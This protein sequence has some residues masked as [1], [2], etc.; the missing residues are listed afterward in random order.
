M[1]NRTLLALDLK[2]DIRVIASGKILSGFH[3]LRTLAMGADMVSSARGM[4]LALGCIRA[5][6]CNNNHCPTGVATEDPSLYKGLIVSDK[7]VRVANYHRETVTA[8]AEL[9]TAAGLE[10]ASDLRRC[11]V[12]R[13]IDME[14]VRTLE[15]IHPY[16]ETGSLLE[17]APPAWLAGDYAAARAEAWQPA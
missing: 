7:R 5:L 1:R 2:R 16:P 13:R 4:M 12:S 11:H 10:T 6:E 14:T 15:E 3:A 9:L 17:A 8:I